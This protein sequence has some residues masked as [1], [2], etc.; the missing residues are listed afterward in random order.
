[1]VLLTLRRTGGYLS[2]AL[3]A[4]LSAALLLLLSGAPASAAQS[5]HKRG[6]HSTKRRG[7][8]GRA[9]RAGNDGPPEATKGLGQLNG[10]LPRNH[11]TEESAIQVNLSNET[12]RLPLYPGTA[13]VPGEPSKTEKVWFVL[14]DAS[15]Q[16][17]A[18][19]LGVNFAPK[20]ANIAIGDPAAVQTVTLDSPSPEQNRF[21][22]A[23]VHF[24]GAPDFSPTRIAEP[25]P[26]GFPLKKFQPGSVAGPGYSPFIKI[27]GSNVVY[28]APIIAAGEGPFDVVHHT[29]TEDRVLGVHIAPPSPPGQFLQSYADLLFVKGFDAG[30]PIVYLSTDAG[31][32]LTAV[33]E[34]STYVPA[35]NEAAY[36]GGDD[37]L[38]SARERLFGFI[39]GQTGQ[40]N[41]Q[42]QGFQHLVLDG[43]AG[44]DAS[45]ENTSLI[46]AL[47]NGGDLLNVF[48]DF[49][50][51]ASPRHADAYSPLW[52]AQLGLW[53]AKAVKEGLNKRQIDENQVFNL[54]ATR[55]DLL[56]GVNPATG[57][58]AP[59]G[60]AG[61]DINC[62]VIGFT[63]DAPTANLAEPVANSQFPPL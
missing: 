12:V 17:L 7:S 62:A 34:R 2:A 28:N 59:Y 30:Q 53:T 42:A 56:T 54:A 49:P 43:H 52:D 19:D 1:M 11:L 24:Q 57:Q 39:N 44:E 27:A 8:H 37:F 41:S 14:L 4:A 9:K 38:G 63:A 55:P 29:N 31:Q 47:R 10:I 60:S 3:L 22:P 50:T 16:G 46:N 18:H 35:L 51:L 6:H 40:S 61:V 13:P 23:V 21:G 45:A 5:H 32:P 20:L 15:D 26:T 36:N 48:G 25:G 33:L 58:P